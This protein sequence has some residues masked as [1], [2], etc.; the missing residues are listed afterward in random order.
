MSTMGKLIDG[1]MINIVMLIESNGK[2]TEARINKMLADH[3]YKVSPGVDSSDNL[4]TSMKILAE[5][6]KNYNDMKKIMMKE[7]P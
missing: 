2:L 6:E 4:K 5:I 1:M 7:L 3:E